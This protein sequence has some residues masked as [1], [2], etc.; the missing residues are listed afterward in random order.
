MATLQQQGQQSGCPSNRYAG[1]V[2]LHWEA[3]IIVISSTLGTQ[4]LDRSNTHIQLLWVVYP[5]FILFN[6]N[7]LSSASLP[8]REEGIF[9][10]QYLQHGWRATLSSICHCNKCNVRNLC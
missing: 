7:D 8:Y 9:S 5:I 10:L 2:I 6:C 1:F 4:R 3:G